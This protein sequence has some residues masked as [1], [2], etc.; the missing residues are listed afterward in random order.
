M[1]AWAGLG[2]WAVVELLLQPFAPVLVG[3]Q[4]AL[5]LAEFTQVGLAADVQ[6][7]DWGLLLQV[8]LQDARL[9]FLQAL[10][11]SQSLLTRKPQLSH[12]C[13]TSHRGRAAGHL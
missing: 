9:C 12:M 4:E 5:V 2:S 13:I 8:H 11:P 6:P 7:Q 1:P 3:V 10:G